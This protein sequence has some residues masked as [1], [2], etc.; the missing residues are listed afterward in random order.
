MVALAPMLRLIATLTLLCAV[1]CDEEEGPNSMHCVER[2]MA[3]LE[4]DFL[5]RKALDL[6]DVDTA[7][8]RA[9]VQDKIVSA[10]LPCF[11]GFELRSQ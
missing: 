6:G 3:W 8:R 10:D 2:R 1:G 5:R 4:I 11:P 7:A 9:L